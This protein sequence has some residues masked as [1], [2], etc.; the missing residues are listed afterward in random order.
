MD[1]LFIEK[2]YLLVERL[3]MKTDT[4]KKDIMLIER[5]SQGLS[6]QTY[7]SFAQLYELLTR[8]VV[9]EIIVDQMN[10]QLAALETGFRVK[11]EKEIT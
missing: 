9:M 2:L 7:S 5:N 8:K 1:I 10:R 3:M 11:L 6:S 4:N